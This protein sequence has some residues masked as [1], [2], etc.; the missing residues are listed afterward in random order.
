MTFSLLHA[1]GGAPLPPI[2]NS[3]FQ[4]PPDLMQPD[5]VV[6]IDQPERPSL[7][8]QRQVVRSKKVSHDVEK[9]KSDMIVVSHVVSRE[10]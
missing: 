10:L 3:I 5:L 4:Y 7:L 9:D 8:K 6:Y 2:T 1:L